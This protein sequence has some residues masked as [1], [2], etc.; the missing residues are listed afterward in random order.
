MTF[1]E[2]LKETVW[3][4][5]TE[6]RVSYRRLRRE[7][8]LDDQTLEDLRI[9]L[10]EGKC[11][12]FDEDGQFLHWSPAPR[13]G[14]EAAPTASP[15]R[16]APLRAG[17]VA[18]S[19]AAGQAAP[20]MSPIGEST[21]SSGER[22]QLTV[23]FC[24][25][26]GSTELST[27]FDPEDLQ[28]IIRGFQDLCAKVVAEFD[29][30]IAEYMGD[31]VL[32]Y[33]G[34]PQ[35]HE[36]DAERAVRTA[37]AI[38]D[39]MPELGATLSAA[40]NIDLAVRIGI[41]TGLVVVG[42]VVGE[43]SAEEKTVVGETPNVAA[44]LQALAMPNAVVIGSVTHDLAGGVLECDDLGTHRLK[45]IADPVHAWRVLGLSDAEASMTSAAPGSGFLV[46]RDEEVGLLLRRWEQSKERHGQ[47]VFI[48]GEP[49][50]GKSTL[51]ETISARVKQEGFTRIAYR[52][53]PYHTNSVLYPVVEQFR[54]LL[55]WDSDDSAETKF[56]KLEE[57]LGAYSQPPAESVPLLAAIMSLPIPEDRYP[58]LGLTPQQQKQQTLDTLVAL[59]LE[60][61]ERRPTMVLW[62]DLHWADASTLEY[63]GLLIDQSPTAAQF[64]VLTFRPDFVPP[65]PMRSHMTPIT[66]NRL[67]RP[68]IEALVRL[69]AGRKELPPEV[70]TH[71]VTKTDGVPLY[72]EELTKMILESNMLREESDRFVLTGPLSSVAILATLQESLMARLDRLPIL[73]EVAQLGAVLGREFAYEML[74]G[75]ADVEEQVLLEGLSQ[76]VESELL[77]QRGRPPRSKYIFKHALVQ[78]AAYQSLLKRTRQKQHEQVAE[79]LASRF[80]EIAETEPELLAHHYTAAG[81]GEPAVGL[82]LQAGQRA[83]RRFAN[84]EAIAHL[85]K[86]LEVLETLPETPERN[87]Q[88]LVLQTTL[89]PP[90]Q[91]IKGYA[92]PEVAAAFG[93]ARELCQDVGETKELFPVL[94]GLWLFYLVRAEHTIAADLAGQL[95]ELA[96]TIDDTTLIVEAQP[97]RGVSAVLMG[98]LEEARSRLEQGVSIYDPSRHQTLSVSY[99]GVD[100]GVVSAA[101]AAWTLWLLGYPEQ[102]LKA[103]DRAWAWT[104]DAHPYT[105]ARHYFWDGIVRQLVGDWD[106]VSL[107]AESAS[108][109]AEEHDYALVRAVGAI[110]QGWA[111]IRRGQRAEGATLVRQG[112][113]AYRATGAEFQLTHLLVPLAEGSPPQE[114]LTV[115]S[116]AL[117]LVETT[118]ERYYEAELHRLKGELLLTISDDNEAEAERCFQQALDIAR[119]RRAKSLELR[120]ALSLCRLW[121]RQGKN[122]EAGQFLAEIYEWFT[123]GFETADLKEARALLDELHTAARDA[124]SAT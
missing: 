26:V 12:A 118:G 33:F 10:I 7:F 94:W 18:A 92:S 62:E 51:V 74:H 59:A 19:P 72:V 40:P 76:L 80:P 42:E 105:Q 67:E 22:R 91:A 14:N 102:A 103:A 32:I 112:L 81:R 16:L 98:E 99:G 90:L 119:A 46:G 44:R 88:E 20:Q 57:V 109:M 95:I 17:G 63:I 85:N 45:G 79:M 66:L 60:E 96:E 58:S 87:R 106:A 121:R 21:T 50:I 122:K 52:C 115:I 117:A 113:E 3:L 8:D 97:A 104:K 116:D 68:L 70:L 100:P 41:D 77:Y 108:A 93:R 64:I 65:W 23:M 78:D 9:E 89:G 30:Y 5:V 36:K 34:Y 75:L 71:V 29:G 15:E 11:L 83:V 84:Q 47:A 56:E 37:L 54:R 31:G 6:G 110:L 39:A 35:A 25:L 48:N 111:L 53:S 27:R 101:Y 2:V 28:D 114:G 86:G 24:D 49:G 61:S 73:R 38:I 69:L 120:G 55:R 124:E 43:G 82:W 123:E 107:N 1:S 4:L 13:A